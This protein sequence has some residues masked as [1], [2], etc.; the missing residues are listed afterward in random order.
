ME[1]GALSIDRQK[2]ETERMFAEVLSKVESLMQKKSIEFDVSLPPKMPELHLDKDKIVAV[3]VN[4][5]GNAAKYTPSGGRV[6]LK[7]KVED[8]K[9]KI[10]VQDTGVGVAEE[11]MPK[12]FD[13]FFRSDD[14]RVQAETGSG[15]GLSLAREVVRMHGGEITVESVLNQGSTF[16]VLLPVS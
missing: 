1:V 16:T 10:A 15:L 2:V 5:L 14:P 13:K 3:V 8:G 7:V 9:L 12:L 4:V 11:E 6:S